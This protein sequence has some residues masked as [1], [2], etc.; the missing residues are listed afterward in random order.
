M[1]DLHVTELSMMSV[2]M[3]ATDVSQSIQKPGA[4]VLYTLWH[5][6]QSKA[7]LWA[8]AAATLVFGL[9]YAP[10]F[11]VLIA[12]WQED[13]NYSHG[14]LVIP[15]A[16][17]ILWQRL[18]GAK[19]EPSAG[20]VPAPWWGWVFLTAVLAL[21]SI[22]YEWNL[23]W[24][25]T[26][27]ILPAIACLTWA[28]GSWPL[29]RRVWLAIAY[30]VF[31]LPLPQSI[32]NLIALPLQRIATSGSCFLLQLS[33]MWAIQPGQGNVIN[34]D[35]PHGMVP[36]DVA[37]ACNGLRMLM[38]M[39][40][41]VVAI[42]ILI[43]LPTWKRIVLLVSVVP[44]AL[45]SNMIRIVTTGWC[46]YLITGPSAKRWAHDLSGWLMMPLALAL[47]GLELCILSWLVPDEDEP[48]ADDGKPILLMTHHKAKNRIGRR[49]FLLNK[50]RGAGSVRRLF[51]RFVGSLSTLHAHQEVTVNDPVWV[52]GI[53]FTPLTLAET[54]A[55]VG[56]L[57]ERG[58]PAYFITA[59]TQYAMLTETDV[60][61]RAFNARAAFVVADGAPLVWASRWQGSPLPER[62]AGSDLIFE[63]S[64]AAAKKGYRLFFL[65]GA[66]GVAEEA[67]RRLGARTLGFRSLA[68][69]ARRFVS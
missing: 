16:V 54:V 42:L 4:K 37:L 8:L 17:G 35:T 38:T 65:G 56:G 57:I 39:V 12:K 28:F 6:R 44:I 31:M 2:N 26:A 32:N 47:V 46:Y 53:P 23:Q 29:L 51:Q 49:S 7:R 60:G 68:L 52:W 63:L 55:A 48:G 25:E 45:L 66:Q 9:A 20:A 30:L 22:A 13:P 5:Q 19:P 11:R 64:A 3:I 24:S 27:T 18:A 61:L 1:W 69:N 40:A 67:A 33:G 59:N 15:I 58:R 62:V 34:L 41:T 36:L 14:F 10:N 21:R 50:D 43:P